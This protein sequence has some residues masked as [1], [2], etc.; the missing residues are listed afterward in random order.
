MQQQQF[1]RFTDE[2]RRAVV[3]AQDEARDRCHD[4]IGPGHLM[5]GVLTPDYGIAAAALA[6][7][8]V[9]RAELRARISGGMPPGRSR[10]ARLEHL[11]FT[12]PTKKIL[13]LTLR[14]ALHLRHKYIGAEHILLAMIRQ[15]EDMVAQTL[16]TFGVDLDSARAEVARL[17]EA[18]GQPTPGGQAAPEATAGGSGRKHD[19]FGPRL[20]EV[21]ARLAVAEQQNGLTAGPDVMTPIPTAP[22]LGRRRRTQDEYLPRLV[23]V[24][25]RLARLDQLHGVPPRVLAAARQR[26]RPADLWARLWSA[27][28]RLA[29]IELQQHQ[30]AADDE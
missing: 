2:A 23:S 14:E 19:D 16:R 21:E 4:H 11:P 12:L 25:S 29:K 17:V 27:D 18:Q 5:L 9:D 8:A 30:L 22:G 1:T 3:W 6:A 26:V 24:E 28:A 7:F 15:Q 20:A 10:S 13:E